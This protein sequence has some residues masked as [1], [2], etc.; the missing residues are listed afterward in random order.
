MT[1]R[2]RRNQS[3]LD[4]QKLRP[5]P[6]LL[7]DWPNEGPSV[8]SRERR[9]LLAISTAI[10]AR[11]AQDGLPGRLEANGRPRLPFGEQ[12]AREGHFPALDRVP[13]QLGK[14]GNACAVLEKDGEL[15]TRRVAELVLETYRGPCLEGYVAYHLDGDKANCVLDNLEWRLLATENGGTP[16]EHL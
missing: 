11:N 8:A 10:E 3:C 5:Q 15:Q 2:V 14:D 9:R 7:V 4:G 6:G 16:S 13:E 1:R 12:D